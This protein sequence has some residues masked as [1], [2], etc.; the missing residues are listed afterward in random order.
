M[1][2]ALRNLVNNKKVTFSA[3]AAVVFMA[4][5]L[6]QT[7]QATNSAWVNT[8]DGTCPTPEGK[9]LH[10]GIFFV[11][12][13]FLMMWLNRSN[14]SDGLI[15]KYS[16][17]AALLFF[18]LTSSDSYA[19]SS[20]LPYMNDLTDLTGCPTRTGVLVHG[21]AFMVLLTMVMYFPK[22]E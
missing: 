2:E 5:S 3:L 1:A 16:F 13:Y 19:L 20:Q 22:D 9:F 7:Y 12:L 4:V 17:Y 6:P 21:L 15:A 14:L 10:T 8:V 18:L 11:V